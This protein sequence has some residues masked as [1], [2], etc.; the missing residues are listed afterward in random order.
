MEYKL[1]GDM[2]LNINGSKEIVLDENDFRYLVEK[3]IG[4]EA[5]D[6]YSA[7]IED[8]ELEIDYL[9]DVIKKLTEEVDTN[10]IDSGE[11]DKC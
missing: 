6:F 10:N 11:I 2:L 5:T 1:G 3:Y 7:I 4:T 8:Y 9:N